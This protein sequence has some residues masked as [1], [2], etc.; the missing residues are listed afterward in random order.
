MLGVKEKSAIHS[1][2]N[3]S[4]VVVCIY[5]GSDIVKRQNEVLTTQYNVMYVNSQ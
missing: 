5:Y 1:Q 4:E 2:S 3:I